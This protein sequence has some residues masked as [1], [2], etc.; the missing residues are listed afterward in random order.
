MPPT[1]VPTRI[2]ANSKRLEAAYHQ[3]NGFEVVSTITSV[4]FQY[5]GRMKL[6]G[7]SGASTQYNKR[8][9]CW[10]PPCWMSPYWIR[11]DN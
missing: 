11:L 3:D 2:V 1:S 7:Q 9:P 8:M 6:R 10:I 4:A 5:S